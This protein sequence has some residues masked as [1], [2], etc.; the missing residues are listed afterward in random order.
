MGKNIVG[1]PYIIGKT[2]DTKGEHREEKIER[3][4]YN[5]KEQTTHRREKRM[6]GW[7]GKCKGRWGRRA[8]NSEKYLTLAGKRVLTWAE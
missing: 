4:K 1:K 6:G 7:A 3:K 5:N 2:F 8:T